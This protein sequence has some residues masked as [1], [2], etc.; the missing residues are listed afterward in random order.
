M[1]FACGQVS[2]LWR[3]VPPR[4]R[5]RCTM[6]EVLFA[7]MWDEGP[8]LSYEEFTEYIGP[9]ARLQSTMIIPKI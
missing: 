3:I 9:W 7:G 5:E 8:N 4:V 2:R 6:A 1:V